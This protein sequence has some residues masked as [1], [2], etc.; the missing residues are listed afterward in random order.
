MYFQ[1]SEGNSEAVSIGMAGITLAV[2]TI[3]VVILGILPSLL[4]NI[5][6]TW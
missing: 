2:A 5:Y 6:R 1:E 3:A 4:L